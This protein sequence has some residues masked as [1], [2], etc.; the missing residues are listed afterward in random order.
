MSYLQNVRARW[1]RPR[2]RRMIIDD[3]IANIERDQRFFKVQM[4]HRKPYPFMEI[5][6]Y[7]REE[8]HK[9]MKISIWEYDRPRG[10]IYAFTGFD[11]LGAI[12]I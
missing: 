4:K 3:K 9:W 5:A 6:S 11:V 7:K 12:A 10:L 1:I 8:W 2:L